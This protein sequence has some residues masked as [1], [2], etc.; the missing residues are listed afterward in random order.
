MSHAFWQPSD[1]QR[2]AI[3][4]LEALGLIHDLGKL[5][6]TFLKS[7]EP[8]A[9][10]E[11][12]HDLLADPRSVGIYNTH[13]AIPGDAAAS[14]AQTILSDAA[15]RPSAFQ[16]RADLTAVL[17]QVTFTDWTGQSYNFAELAPLVAHP[18]LAR[19]VA[20]WRGVLTK[21]MQPGFLVGALH[22]TA[23]IE[24]EGEPDQH[25]QPYNHIFRATPFGLEEQI[26][27]VVSQ[28]LTD[29]LNGLPLADIENITTTQRSDWLAQ[30]KALMS[31]GL[32]D[33]R[34]PHNEVSLWDWG[35]TVATLTKAAAAYIFK[36]GWPANLN[37]LPYRTLRVN[38]GILERYTHSDK[39]SDLLGVRQALNEASPRVQTLLEETYAL[40]NCFYRDETGIYYLLPDIFDENELAALRREIQACF[41]PDLRP[42]VHLGER[43]TA[44]QLDGRSPAH[45]PGALR[46][47]VAEPRAQAL[48][49]APTQTDNNLYLFEGEWTEGR[50]ANAE[51]CMA[52]GARPV[53]Y[54][55]HGSLGEAERELSPWATQEKAERRNICRVCLDR[56]GRRAEQ[57]AKD[58]LQG[59]I[60]TDE[61]ADDNGRLALFVG[62][63]DLEGWLDG[64]MLRTLKVKDATT[65]NPS[66]ARLYR[67][68]ETAR[69]FWEQVTGKLMPPV[70][71]QRPSRLALYP[72]SHSPLDL[73]HFHAYE[74]EVDGVALNVVWDKPNDR[75]LTADNLTYL[76]RR[77][78][79]D[80]DEIPT[81]VSGRRVQVLEPSSFLNTGQPLVKAFI[82]RVER[83]DGYL[84]AIPLLTEPSAC[85]MLVPADRA[86][87]LTLAVK[88]EYERQMGRVRDRLPLCLGLVFCHRRTPVR[89]VLEAGRAMLK[90]N[91][92]EKWEGWRLMGK[93]SP[94]T[95]ECALTFDNGITWRVPVVA[96]DG[97]TKDEWY[98]RMY[99]G[100][101]WAEGQVR[102]ATDLQVSDP[103]TPQNS[104]NKVWIRP[105]R[106][107]FEFLD[108]AS[109]RFEIHYDEH[110][111]RS[112]RTRPF[113]LED[114]DR[115]DELWKRMK[116]L[117]VSQRH[118]VIRTIE[119]TREEWY[120]ADQS[121]QAKDDGVFRQFVTD[122]L[123]G[124]AWPKDQPWRGIP[125]GLRD[126]LIQA[127]ASGELTDLAELH[128]EI[129]KERD[130]E[131]NP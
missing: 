45:D 121:A 126:K 51:T 75:F 72:Q 73:G 21:A 54:P 120:G 2:R 129:L 76:G 56:R 58:G 13:A 99:E 57:W 98:P 42:R 49:E 62:K 38:L 79:M 109:R 68:A 33:N 103:G 30:M 94:N 69:Q 19:L 37:D 87:S 3:L 47:L 88:N 34:R 95:G 8:S 53:G 25:Q 102:H 44:G 31:R 108:A 50:P 41:P 116:H 70:I 84:P 67:I 117:A 105:S 71:G 10:V 9:T 111:R 119:A 85:L 96:G 15:I 107:D 86:L 113:Y 90:M 1:D 89:A 65:K 77:L 60:W 92:G 110:G 40:G 115:F 5:S 12:N 104:G 106:F 24:K 78:E 29:A 17:E 28:E 118:Q 52:C 128:M 27:T 4:L 59:T 43:I 18:G 130:K 32:A 6:D 112:R 122:T 63:L 23:H 127:G 74:V 80:Q 82:E 22:G 124:A 101:T 39:I 66:P 91:A 46:R 114:L 64:K 16:E 93:T 131:A 35:Y 123:A 11:Y 97:A 7:K 36:N 100:D 81:R 20:N 125:Q 14:Y 26:G 48:G 61:V 55:R 83:L